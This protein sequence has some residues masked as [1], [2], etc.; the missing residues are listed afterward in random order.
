MRNNGWIM[1]M[2]KEMIESK[3]VRGKPR[4]IFIKQIMKT[5]GKQLF[6]KI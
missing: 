6:T 1:T 3:A 2:V 5:Q 4:T